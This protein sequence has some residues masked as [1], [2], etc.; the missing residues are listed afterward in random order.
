MKIAIADQACP[1]PTLFLPAQKVI[2]ICGPKPFGGR[3][4]SEEGEVLSIRC[5]QAL[6]HFKVRLVKLL[7][8]REALA[9]GKVLSYN[10]VYWATTKTA[11]KLDTGSWLSR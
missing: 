6:D 3:P 4:R 10:E 11:Q 5:N 9:G 2:L 7:R 8:R 1:G